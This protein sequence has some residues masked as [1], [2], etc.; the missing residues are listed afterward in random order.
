M[1][2]WIEIT[3]YQLAGKLPDTF[4]L[5]SG[6]RVST[7]EDW[8]Q[9]RK[10]LYETAVELQYGTMPPKPEFLELEPL[11]L[12]GVG[13]PN[14]YRIHT[15]TRERPI[16]LNM[17]V[18]K[19]AK[20]KCPAVIDG[21]LCFPYPYDKEFIKQFTD[22]GIHFVAFNRTELAPDIADYNLRQ[23][24]P[25]SNEPAICTPVY[26]GLTTGNCGGAL[27][28]TYP[29]RTFGAIGA[30]SWGYSRCV[31]ALELLGIADLYAFTGHSRGGKTAL[32]AG[33]L[34]ERAAIVNPNGSGT[35]GAACY[36][37]SMKAIHEDGVEK[38]SEPTENIIRVFPAWMG[39]AMKDFAGNE[40]EL[41]F[42]CHDLKALV[43]P[44]VLLDTE[45]ASDIWANPVG[46]WQTNLAARE[47][48]KFHGCKENLLW[49][50][51]SGYHLHHLEDIACLVDVIRHVHTGGPLQGEYNNLVFNAQ[52]PAFDWKCPE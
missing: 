9:R 38:P 45:A 30:W 44:R 31:D 36:R 51:R 2:N 52:P 42:D 21:D 39:P 27:K 4:L 35:C 3:D 6:K 34:D 25:D 15:G 47:V 13:K 12:T 1:R 50:Y 19:A 10:E 37:V 48:Y 23:L 7:M 16:T 11:C 43:A 24:D 18:F 29:D 46:T 26:D 41:P 17:V 40:T 14:T 22:N 20:G 8:Q 5:N 33:V 49:H 28:R 32:L